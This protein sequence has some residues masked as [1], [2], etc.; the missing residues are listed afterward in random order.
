M[1]QDRIEDLLKDIKT[2]INGINP[3][4]IQGTISADNGGTAVTPRNNDRNSATAS[5]ITDM[6]F[7]PTVTLGSPTTLCTKVLGSGKSFGGG[8]RADNE[9]ILKQGTKYFLLITNQATGA[10]NE[11]NIQF[12]YYEHTNRSA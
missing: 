2:A 9:I 6:V 12:E 3:V 8:E 10:S 1:S 4:S 5:G 7:D 11:T